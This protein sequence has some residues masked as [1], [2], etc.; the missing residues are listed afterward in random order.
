MTTAPHFPVH[1]RGRNLKN[2][3]IERFANKAISS[4]RSSSAWPRE[5]ISVTFRGRDGGFADLKA[6]LDRTEAIAAI[7]WRVVA[8]LQARLQKVPDRHR[9]HY[10]PAARFEILEI[11]HLMAWNQARTAEQFLVATNTIANWDP[12]QNPE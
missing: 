8:L 10:S 5:P 11:R 4:P 3:A 2:A 9:P 6:R 7:A 1:L 12:E